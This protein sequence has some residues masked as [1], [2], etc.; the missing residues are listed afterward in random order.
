[1]EHW[2]LSQHRVVC[3]YP[4]W[5]R[6][7]NCPNLESVDCM[8]QSKSSKIT[9]LNIFSSLHINLR[10][11]WKLYL[12][13]QSIKLIYVGADLPP[14]TWM[15]VRCFH[16]TLP[17]KVYHLNTPEKYSWYHN[18]VLSKVFVAKHCLK[19]DV[20]PWS[21]ELT[22]ESIIMLNSIKKRTHCCKLDRFAIVQDVLF[23][24]GSNSTGAMT[25]PFCV[26]VNN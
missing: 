24:E 5:K 25:T 10:G 12:I 22:A 11:N 21:L 2:H 6:F 4:G 16:C 13:S 9:F 1:M 17:G 15:W 26:H 23:L 19:R 7:L 18:M 14:G 8:F 3:P 20:Y